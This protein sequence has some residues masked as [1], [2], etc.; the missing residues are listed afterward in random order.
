[1][2]GNGVIMQ[3]MGKVYIIINDINLLKGTLYYDNNQKAYE[4]DFRDG[5]FNNFGH[6]YN[7]NPAS[8]TKPFDFQ[9]F[10]LLGDYWYKYEGDF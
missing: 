5:K 8:S 4:G 3:W 1:M 6:L 10:K 2:K 7:R 9:N